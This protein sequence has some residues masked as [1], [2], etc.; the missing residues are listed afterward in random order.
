MA[1]RQKGD[2]LT[3]VWMDNKVVSILSTNTQP[4]ECGIIGRKQRNGQKIDVPCPNS[5]MAYT[6]NMGGVDRNDQ[7]RQYYMVRLKSRKNYKYI[8]W[9][10]FDLAI[11]NSYILY[12]LYN[13]QAGNIVLK[14]FRLDLAKQL[15]GS[16][17]SRKVPGRPPARPARVHVL[18]PH[19]PMRNRTKSN[20]GMSRC[21][22]CSLKG[23][24][25]RETTWYC[26]TCKV[27][28]CHTGESDGTDCFILY[29]E[30]LHV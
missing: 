3:T 7:L 4:A 10:L 12:K 28:L 27:H 18:L 13:D 21:K 1:Q 14:N 23:R 20:K 11:T 16:Y 8:F 29:H 2:L 25:K 6:E 5:I 19:H 9:Y 17:N 26:N 22:Y 15:I 24:K 30:E